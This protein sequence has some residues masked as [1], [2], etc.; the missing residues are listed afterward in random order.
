MKAASTILLVVLAFVAVVA[1]CTKAPEATPGDYSPSAADTASLQQDVLDLD[2]GI[3][4]MSLDITEETPLS[5][6]DFDLGLG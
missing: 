2:Q 6:A 5:D 4:D 1:G 3:A